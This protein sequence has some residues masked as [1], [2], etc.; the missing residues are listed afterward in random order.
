MK[1]AGLV[2]NV[3]VELPPAMPRTKRCRACNRVRPLGFFWRQGRDTRC[4][5][6]RTRYMRRWIASHREYFDAWQRAYKERHRDEIREYHREYQ[7]RRR[8][9]IRAGKWKV[10]ARRGAMTTRARH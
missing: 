7:R 10:G 2:G 6:C 3:A 5:V 8:A 9:L 1:P 4:K